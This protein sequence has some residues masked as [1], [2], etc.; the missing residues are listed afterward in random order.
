MRA[1]QNAGLLAVITSLPLGCSSKETDPPTPPGAQTGAISGVVTA[2]DDSAIMGAKV[3]TTPATKMAVTDAQGR[4][5]LEQI[6]PGSY[7][8]WAGADGYVD[9]MVAEVEVLA[10]QTTQVDMELPPAAAPGPTCV[11]CHMDLDR[12]YASLEEDPP[13]SQ[14]HEGGS[15]GE[16]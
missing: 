8:V 12:L 7:E 1:I 14:P 16:G 9:V 3:T 4:F 5:T 6:A 11:S 13:V 2:E 15:A 10:D